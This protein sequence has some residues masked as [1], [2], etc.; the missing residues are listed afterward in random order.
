MKNIENS[1]ANTTKR[2]IV[3]DARRLLV[4]ELE[5]TDTLVKENV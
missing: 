1:D 3:R 5:E 4:I 2:Q